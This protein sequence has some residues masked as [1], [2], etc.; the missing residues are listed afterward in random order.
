[1]RR[2]PFGRTRASSINS[3]RPPAENENLADVRPTG[4]RLAGAPHFIIKKK[5]S[6]KKRKRTTNSLRLEKQQT[7]SQ[8]LKSKINW[9]ADRNIKNRP[10]PG[11]ICFERR[12]RCWWLVN[13]RWTRKSKEKLIQAGQ[14]ETDMAGR[15]IQQ[16]APKLDAR[17]IKNVK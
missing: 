7:K 12:R 13:S 15:C 14:E 6:R 17:N 16:P 5:K 10:S 1:M 4:A 8:G 9:D 2:G 11:W 3:S